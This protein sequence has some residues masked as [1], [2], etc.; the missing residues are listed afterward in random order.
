[1][2]RGALVG[3][4]HNKSMLVKSDVYEDGRA[5]TLMS[6][7]TENITNTVEMFHETWARVLEVLLV[8]IFMCSRVSRYVARNLQAKQKEWNV[9]TQGR[10]AMTSSMLSSIKGLKMLGMTKPVE[11]LLQNLRIHEIEI[12]KRVRWIMV[13]YN[14]SANALGIFSPVITFVLFT[15]IVKVKGSSLDTE[16]AF[17]TTAILGMVTHPANMIMTII[18]QAIASLADFERIHQYLSEPIMLDQR[19]IL[20]KDFNHGIDDTEA[21]PAIRIER[22]S[23]F[24]SST[25]QLILSGIDLAVNKGFTVACSGPVGSGKSALAQAI[26][27]ELPLSSG[28]IAV[29]ST[30]IGLCAQSAWLPSTT[31]SQAIRGYTAMG[32]SE[33]YEEV[34]CAC[35]LDE[36]LSSFSAGDN[37]MIGSRGLNLSRGQRQRVALARALYAR[38]EIIILDDSFSALDWKTESRILET[39]FGPR[40]L[41]KRTRTTVF[42]ITNAIQQLQL[43]DWVVVLGNSTIKDQGSWSS[44]ASKRGQMQNPNLNNSRDEST[45]EVSKT[46]N[47]VQNRKQGVVEAADDLSRRTGDIALY[48]Y[49]IRSVGLKNF[50]LMVT[51]TALYS[52]FIT[53]PQYWLKWWTDAGPNETW[54][55]IG[56]YLLLSLIAW[57]STNGTMSTFILLAPRSGTLLH[58]SIVSTVIGAPLSYFSAI[59]T[60]VI[61]NRFSQDIQLVDRQLPQAIQALSNQL[62]K[63]LVQAI[64][65]FSAQKFM[66]LLLPFGIVVVYSVQKIYL[67]TS[68]QL[69]LLELESRSAIYSSFL[70]SV[71]GVATIRAFG[72]KKEIEVDNNHYLEKSQQPLYILFCLQRWLNIVLDLMIAAIATGVITLAVV[73]RGSTTGGQIGVALNLVLVANS[74]L[75]RLVESWATLEISL[76]A[77]ARIKSLQNET[78][79]EDKPLENVEPVGSWPS[80][81][82]LDIQNVT[83]AYNPEAIALRDINLN[84][85]AGQRVVI[86]GRTG[87]GKSTLF[88]SLLRLLDTQSGTIKVDGIDLRFIPRSLV[89]QRCFITVPQDAVVLGHASLRF[90]LDPTGSFSDEAITTALRKTRLDSHFSYRNSSDSG[91]LIEGDNPTSITPPEHYLDA[92]VTSLP[93]LSTGQSQL[94][95]LTR[96]ILHAQNSHNESAQFP[97][98]KPIL[99]LDEATASLDPET[100]FAICDIIHREFTEKQHTVIAITHRLSGVAQEMR[101]G[102]DV[103]AWLSKGM[104]EGTREFDI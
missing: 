94:F 71:E 64:L 83:V 100:E 42:L 6:T 45:N 24:N 97:S 9:A 80:S 4:I 82:A 54:F 25:S 58:Y 98:I 2:I 88:L 78:P 69:R 11:S 10:I 15:I 70:E 79:K 63:L 55:Y 91:V 76:G 1:M 60:G 37:T 89:R 43:A 46:R 26:I 61:L 81:G 66:T 77:I 34:I 50:F 68:R 51:C 72:W 8:I 85:S 38:C 30:R 12:A 90:N 87:S 95:S 17:T 14:A 44:I 36:D 5:V 28:T 96:A 56:G 16:T 62:F 49:Y 48:S 33:W 20:K 86:C 41:F 47:D 53:F 67:R 84:V 73:L 75:L 39:L 29:S 32:S 52:F 13:A 103:V 7:D 102:Q 99:L 21:I 93:P 92:P 35:C 3:L 65:L 40:G 27:G 104:L 101:Q 23:I 19:L 22:M 74:T 31:I 57:I 18:P 59:D